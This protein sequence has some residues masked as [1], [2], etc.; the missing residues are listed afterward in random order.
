MA[1]FA[2]YGFPKAHAASYARVA[3]QSA[4]CKTHHPA[5]FMAAVLANWGGYYGQRVYLTEARRLGLALRPPHVN[6]A[7]PEFSARW[8]DGQ[9]VLFMGLNQV[10]ELT[11][12]T[13]A[14]I[15]RQRP[16]TSLLDF[17]ARADP[18]PQEA[19]NLA[20]AGALDGLGNDPGLLRQS[21]ARRL[22]RRAVAAVRSG[23][24][25][26]PGLDSGGESRCP[27]GD[28]G[29]E[30]RCPPAGATRRADRRQRRA[31]HGRSGCPPGPAGARGGYAPD[32]AAQP[33]QSRRL[34]ST[35][36]RWKTWKACW[37]W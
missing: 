35:S 6:Y 20:R 1:A 15:L 32:L 25:K 13:Q 10:R 30:C 22:A 33:V 34:R 17:L 16:F 11:R 31:D 19:R 7:M 3:W 28:A 37:R 4:W 5:V 12:R 26:R 27:G 29:G 9:A 18:R 24:G 23:R 8:L 36:W 21:A 14:R 2:G